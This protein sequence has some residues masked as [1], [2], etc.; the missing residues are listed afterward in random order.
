MKIVDKFKSL[1]RRKKIIF[2]LVLVAWL[3]FRIAFFA[4][5]VIRAIA[6]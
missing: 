4:V 6:N 5:P 1:S 3:I 2:G